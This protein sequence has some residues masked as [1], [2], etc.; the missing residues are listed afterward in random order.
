MKRLG[1]WSAHQRELSLGTSA[2]LRPRK[3]QNR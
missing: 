1:E 2:I 3:E